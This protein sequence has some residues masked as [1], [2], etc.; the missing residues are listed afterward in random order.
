MKARKII[1]LLVYNTC[2]EFKYLIQ[3]EPNKSTMKC[4]ID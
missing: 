2:I 4:E 3:Q 1:Y